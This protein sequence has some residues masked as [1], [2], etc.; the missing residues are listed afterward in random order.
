MARRA[1]G[2]IALGLREMKATHGASAGGKLVYR[3]VHNRQVHTLHNADEEIGQG[4]VVCAI[5]G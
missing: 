5:E 1:V 3:Q 4:I 2:R